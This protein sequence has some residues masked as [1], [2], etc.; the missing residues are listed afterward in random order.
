[1]IF[2][3]RGRP[4]LKNGVSGV[5]LA[6]ALLAG[7][8]LRGQ[9]VKPPA[10]EP[11]IDSGTVFR[12]DTRV[13]D[14][15]ATV[16]D[17]SGHLVTNLPRQA[18][19]VYENGVQQMITNFKREDA[20]VSLGLIVDNSGSMRD[21]RSKVEAAALT[22]VKDSNPQDEVFVVNF[23]DEA[24]KDL[25]HGKDFTSDIKEM[26]EALK[27]ID[28]RGGTAMRDAIRFSIDHLK[29][30]AHR[31]K[32]V[33]VVVTDGNLNRSLVTLANVVRASQQSGVLIYPVGLLSEEVP[34]E[35]K[36]AQQAL[37]A[38]AEAT[39]GETFF[40][41]EVSEVERIAHTVAHNI[42]NQYSIV[43]T[44]ADQ[45]M[46]GT[47]RLIKVTVNAPGSLTVRSRSGY[48]ATP[49]QAVPSTRAPAR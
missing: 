34:E 5:F 12:S 15:H 3:G 9:P 24:Y 10:P 33:L 28:S 30:K 20:P 26:E 18:F 11:V 35:A 4:T 32:K 13:V 19:T 41:K 17:S 31:E 27:R 49:D 1:M 42:R 25:P 14:L 37:G 45:S 47:F 46:D 48:Y 7:V 22:L 36:R 38:L 23:N 6:T 29:E 16:M 40:P 8:S 43:Y 2:L 39:G 21:K 44:P